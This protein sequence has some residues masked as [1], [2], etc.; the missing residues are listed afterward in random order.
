[1]SN[2][3]DIPSTPRGPVPVF[4]SYADELATSGK[5]SVLTD[6]EREMI[7]NHN[8][9][10]IEGKLKSAAS[11]DDSTTQDG[12]SSDAKPESDSALKTFFDYAKSIGG[13]PADPGMPGMMAQPVPPMYQPNTGMAPVQ[14]IAQNTAYMPQQVPVPPVYIPQTAQSA[15]PGVY[16][17]AF[18]P[19]AGYQPYAQPAAVNP[20]CAYT[21]EKCVG[22]RAP[23]LHLNAT[24]SN[25]RATP[26]V[27]TL[28]HAEDITLLEEAE[29]HLP[30]LVLADIHSLAALPTVEGKWKTTI[31]TLVLHSCSRSLF[32]KDVSPYLHSLLKYAREVYVSVVNADDD[33]G[34]ELH[35]VPVSYAHVLLKSGNVPPQTSDDDRIQFHICMGVSL[36][37]KHPITPTMG[38]SV[39]A[40]IARCLYLS[41]PKHIDVWSG[42]NNYFNSVAIA[43]SAL[44]GIHDASSLVAWWSKNAYVICTYYQALYDA[45]YNANRRA[46]AESQEVNRKYSTK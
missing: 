2:T 32:A 5:V 19:S 29:S 43:R 28:D 8:K 20:S 6:E 27:Y 9:A 1:M 39:A 38:T 37:D 3:N 12:S 10:V 26:S 35:G 46:A 13:H 25:P 45:A 4:E 15:A 17:S 40:A 11:S 18:T 44:S 30:V 14:Y 23:F 24:V 34:N 31:D 42:V 21:L 33:V 36:L 22:T 7:R 41:I 16:A